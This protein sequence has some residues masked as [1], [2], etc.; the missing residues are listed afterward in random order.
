MVHQPA[1]CFGTPSAIMPVR[2]RPK[3]LPDDVKKRLYVVHVSESSIPKDSG[4]TVAPA[5][6]EN[7][8]RLETPA[9]AHKDAI[10]VLELICSVGMLSGISVAQVGVGLGEPFCCSRARPARPAHFS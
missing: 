6:V 5:G 1:S 3:D 8:V 10:A 2:A 7:T 4:L 9:N